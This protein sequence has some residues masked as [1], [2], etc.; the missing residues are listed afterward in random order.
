M[1]R[2][3]SR[4][5]ALAASA[6]VAL[7]LGL[8]RSAAA[9]PEGQSTARGARAPNPTG[10]QA[11]ALAH[12]TIR[13]VSQPTSVGADDDFPVYVSVTG[14]SAHSD[15]VVDIYDRVRSPADLDTLD[16]AASRA[17]FDRI[18]LV[19]A[20]PSTSRV[21][22]FAIQLYHRGGRS[23]PDTAWAYR[24]DQP[25]VYPVR[26]H[27]RDRDGAVRA[28]LF[29]TLIRLPTADQTVPKAHVTV[30]ATV[31][32]DVPT[33]AES[34]AGTDHVDASLARGL[35]TL[36][37]VLAAHPSVP[38]TLHVTPD[39]AERLRGRA[40]TAADLAVLRTQLTKANRALLDA[41]FVDIDAAALVANGLEPE[42]G[43]QRDLGR[44]TLTQLLGPPLTDT[45]SLDGPV[46]QATLN[47]LR[48]RGTYRVLL[49][50]AAFAGNAPVVP[51]DL[52]AGGGVV[53][54]VAV[55]PDLAVSGAGSAD[56]T[57]AAHRVLAR[58]SVI[59]LANPDGADLV[60]SVDARS[61]DGPSLSLLM[62]ALT[63]GTPYFD[64]VSLTNLMDDTAPTSTTPPA[65]AAPHPPGLGGYPEQSRDVHALLNSYGS[66]VADDATLIHPFDRPLALTAAANLGIGARIGDLDT[67]QAELQRL[68]ASVSTPANDRVTLGARDAR[69]P[70]VIG[71]TVH[72][73]LHVIVELQANDRLDFPRNQ[74]PV[75]LASARTVAQIRVRTRAS[76]DTPVLIT[77]RSADGRVILAESR[78][79]IRSTAVSGVGVLITIGAA[80]FLALW[81]IRSW[82]SN[83]YRPRRS[84]RSSGPG[85]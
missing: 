34:R 82:Y 1:T 50:S 21:T 2:S 4:R 11:T 5:A 54:A 70:L 84:S 19:D 16:H 14:A 40:R 30:V 67:V 63:I 41:P 33:D 61:V 79:R 6:L 45:W 35:T 53:R 24:L 36:T 39:T 59:A 27:L 10:A 32:Q 44:Q 69:F 28:T 17:T 60:I 83:R 72:Y 80:G 12:P 18:P 85:V 15:L 74:L 76:G 23:R 38:T 51:V 8:P 77:I 68:F 47:A 57:L 7:V 46:D 65:L 29:T 55:D 78:Y 3:R 48:N 22:G 42:L 37:T 43:R 56:P 52:A 31:H 13:L 25:G 62:D 20:P 9:S 75:T 81:W 66:M 26:I 73:P 49:P 58:L 71:S 64:T